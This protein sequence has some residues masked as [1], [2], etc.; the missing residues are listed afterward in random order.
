MNNNI[1]SANY[2][3]W[4]IVL[5]LGILMNV[6]GYSTWY[7]V[8]GRYEVNKIISTMLLLPITGV[9]TAIIFLG[10]RPDFNTYIG[11][12]VIIIG[13]SLILLGK[14]NIKKTSTQQ[15]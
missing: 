4:L 13:V 10:E 6:L 1:I 8:L 11:G 12:L 2:Q 14:K 3:S 7:Y 5:Y 9:L 15:L